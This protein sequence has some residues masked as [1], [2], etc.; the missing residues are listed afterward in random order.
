[1][2]REAIAHCHDCD[3]AEGEQHLYGCDMERCPFCGAQLIGC[4]CIYEY[5]GINVDPGTE[6]FD[7]DV[8]MNG[9]SRQDEEK[10]FEKM[11]VAGRI[12]YIRV[13]VMC[14]TCGELWPEM[15]HSDDW[16]RVVPRELRGHVLCFSCFERMRN[17]GAN[18][19][20]FDVA[21]RC[22]LCGTLDVLPEKPGDFAL[23]VPPLCHGNNYVSLQ[24]ERLCAPCFAWLKGLMPKGWREVPVRRSSR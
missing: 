7:E 20:I 16:D 21:P 14:V 13:P 19:P 12:P 3:A 23:Y 8:Y 18:D 9:P 1:M 17:A 5:L 24:D 11:V 15:F 6:G 2:P 10:F 4:H 22:P